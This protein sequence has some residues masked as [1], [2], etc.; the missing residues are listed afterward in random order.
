MK[1]P[2]QRKPVERQYMRLV[3]GLKGKPTRA[4]GTGEP[5]HQRAKGRG[6]IKNREDRKNGGDYLVELTTFHVRPR[7]LRSRR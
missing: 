7:W 1:H 3:V 2:I 4:G 5:V 6:R